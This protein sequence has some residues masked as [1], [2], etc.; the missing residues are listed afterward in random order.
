MLLREGKQD[1]VGFE[2]THK[3]TSCKYT[4]AIER[5]QHKK[6]GGDGGGGRTHYFADSG[7]EQNHKQST[8]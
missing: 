2:R 5:E 7:A 6:D 1:K 8:A 3:R 4:V